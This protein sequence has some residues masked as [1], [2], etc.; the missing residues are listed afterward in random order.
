MEK[1]L[2]RT[3]MSWRKNQFFKISFLLHALLVLSSNSQAQTYSFKHFG[4]EKNVFPSRIETLNQAST[5]EL[6]VGTLAG[7]VVYDGQAFTQVTVNEGLAEN[8]ISTVYVDGNTVWLGHWAG[9]MTRYNLRDKNVERFVLQ[10]S[11][12]FNSIQSIVNLGNNELLLTTSAGALFRFKDGVV[13]QEV[14]ATG[15][16]NPSIKGIVQENGKLYAFG[17]NLVFE[18]ETGTK[19]LKWKQVAQLTN[20]KIQT[21]KK[22]V[23]GYWLVGTNAGLVAGKWDDLQLVQGTENFEITSVSSDKQLV[24]CGTMANGAFSF[25][26]KTNEIINI[27]RTNGLSYNQVRS[28]FVDREQIL[29][30]AT[31]AG[32]DQYLGGSF[33]FFDF[34]KNSTNSLIWDFKLFDN[35]VIT[36]T[37]DGVFSSSILGAN[38]ALV[39]ISNLSKAEP[40]KLLL[41][42]P[43]NST[44]VVDEEGKLLKYS[45]GSNAIEEF[46]NITAFARCM[47][48]IGS[49]IWVGTDDGIYVLENGQ[50]VTHYDQNNGL[51]GQKVNGIY[52]LKSSKETWITFLGGY[53]TVLRNGRFKQFNEELGITSKVIQDAAFDPQGNV[54]LA[55]YDQGLFFCKGDTFHNLN[56]SNG[57]NSNT[58]FAI[59]IDQHGNV[60]IGHNWGLDLYRIQYKDFQHFGVDEGFMGLEVNPGAIEVADDGS[61]W[62]GTL[63]GLLK[64]NP[65]ANTANMVEPIIQLK[66]ANLGSENLLNLEDEVRTTEND[67]RIVF[68]G[69]SLVNPSKNTFKY[70]L[71]GIHNNWKTATSNAPIEYFSLPPG[72]Y[73]FELVACNNNGQCNMS[74]LK[75]SFVITPPFYRSWWF[76]T[77][78]FF[79]SVMIIFF[80]DRYRA[81]KLIEEKNKL[82]EKLEHKEQMLIEINQEL[83]ELISI[84]KQDQKLIS[85]IYR[86]K[87]QVQLV[88]KDLFNEL[89]VVQFHDS[90]YRSDHFIDIKHSHFR[91]VG[92]LNTSLSG[93]AS[94]LLIQAIKSRFYQIISFLES[95]DFNDPEIILNAF[96]Q[97]AKDSIKSLKKFKGIEW[98]LCLEVNGLKFYHQ[99]IMSIFIQDQDN[100]LELM[101]VERGVNDKIRLFHLLQIDKTK[102]IFAATSGLFEM[103]NKDNSKTF[104]SL[105]F[106]K[107]LKELKSTSAK[108]KMDEVINE[109][110]LWKSDQISNENITLIIWKHA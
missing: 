86:D 53:V 55:S 73:N 25:D 36:A 38:K 57:L 83:G 106:V 45:K 5:G 12:N 7:L 76:Y 9:N 56:R 72:F 62:M 23:N 11:L 24:W 78:L 70:R 109:L 54:W 63:M 81:V 37:G 99:N 48:K 87:E 59:D 13:E 85:E 43:S 30:V 66:S 69:I 80:M 46:V 68:N 71:S 61:V 98:L 35:E 6:L 110:N 96:D 51:G 18:S 33:T 77:L 97:A 10:E 29:W 58:T 50:I 4:I 14:L 17:E 94:V 88:A 52:H 20:V 104:S 89:A 34:S 49:Q 67:L 42:S 101:A 3:S 91:L 1:K 93:A 2:L 60:W 40:R 21:I 41:D 108:E 15:G 102:V 79:T 103:M 16:S 27:K 107:L 28:V 39:R 65:T 82:S 44:Y 22:H 19:A 8:A 105:Q 84:E 90:V 100:I 32:L 75:L 26:Y 74:P 64:F 47:E 31:A 92:L 95:N